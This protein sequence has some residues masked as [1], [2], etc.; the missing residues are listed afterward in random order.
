[1][2]MSIH[3]NEEKPCQGP[4]CNYCF[5]LNECFGQQD[6]KTLTFGGPHKKKVLTQ[7]R[8]YGDQCGQYVTSYRY[9]DTVRT[10]D[11][12]EIFD[13]DGVAY[14]DYHSSCDICQTF[15]KNADINELYG[16]KIY[17]SGQTPH[18]RTWKLYGKS[19]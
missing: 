11:G 12:T 10:H 16:A 8:L 15:T 2:A 3:T 13:D 6:I 7:L 14:S 1:M 9:L 17:P 5:I 19:K 18:T 4:N